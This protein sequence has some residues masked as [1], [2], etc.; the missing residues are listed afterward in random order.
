MKDH[1]MY[2]ISYASD[3]IKDCVQRLKHANAFMKDVTE[4]LEKFQ[5]S[6]S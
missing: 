5:D 2:H 4:A 6:E 3:D 1:L